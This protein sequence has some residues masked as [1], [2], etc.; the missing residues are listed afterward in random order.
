LVALLACVCF[1]A[2][3]RG[4][5]SETGT[6]GRGG[7]ATQRG[8]IQRMGGGKEGLDDYNDEWT[9]TTTTMIF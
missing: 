9:T 5:D 2:Y 3:F 7:G 1:L 4:S 6:G 8:K